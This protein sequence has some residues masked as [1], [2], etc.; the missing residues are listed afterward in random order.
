MG[1]RQGL[2]EQQ[3]LAEGYNS[4]LEEVPGQILVAL[5]AEV[6]QWT[7]GQQAL[8]LVEPQFEILV[9]VGLG[10]HQAPPQPQQTQT[11]N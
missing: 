11:L 8:D 10:L 3:E 2:V 6:A 7:G 9:K 5:L 1:P 4:S